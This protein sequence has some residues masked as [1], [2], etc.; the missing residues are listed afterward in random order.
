MSNIIFAGILTKCKFF[1]HNIVAFLIISCFSGKHC[2]RIWG[3]LFYIYKIKAAATPPPLLNANKV[4]YFI[5]WQWLVISLS[6]HFKNNQST[7]WNSGHF[8][9]FHPQISK[10]YS[11][12]STTTTTT[13]S[14]ITFIYV[15]ILLGKLWIHALPQI[16]VK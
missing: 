6:K 12:F 8:I 16:W 7:V 3:N 5:P 1:Q 4:C 13:I 11:S 14:F 9:F 15:Q 10:W 2:H